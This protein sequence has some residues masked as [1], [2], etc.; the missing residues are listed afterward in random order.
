MFTAA[1]APPD[2]AG[3]NGA[4]MRLVEGLVHCNIDAPGGGLD[5][6]LS[7]FKCSQSRRGGAL[8]ECTS[9]L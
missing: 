6:P 2:E 8:L 4:G 7:Y 1:I 5:M 3:L 9:M